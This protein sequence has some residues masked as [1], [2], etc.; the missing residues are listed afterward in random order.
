MDKSAKAKGVSITL[1]IL[2]VGLYFLPSLANAVNVVTSSIIDTKKGQ[3]V[4]FDVTI[5]IEEGDLYVP[6]NYTILTIKSTNV[7]D[8]DKN[9]K[10]NLECKIFVDGTYDCFIMKGNKKE[11]KADVEIKTK[12]H[13]NK[14]GDK[15]EKKAD[16]AITT[17]INSSFGFGFGEFGYG[18]GF[19]TG[20]P[21]TIVHNINWDTPDSIHPGQYAAQA[22]TYANNVVFSAASITFNIIAG[23]ADKNDSDKS[24]NESNKPDG[25]YNNSNIKT[26]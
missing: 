15:K 10:E 9:D 21:G 22:N 26:T 20:E 25:K 13:F 4:S 24:H 17:E 7:T 19:G 3:P 12:H 18:N 16:V 11:K 14:K 1:T 6:L 5:N 23:K 8:K 2:V